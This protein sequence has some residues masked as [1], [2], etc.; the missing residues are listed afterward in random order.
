[1]P[2]NMKAS[3][4]ELESEALTQV[5][6]LGLAHGVCMY[7]AQGQR[8]TPRE[9]TSRRLGVGFV[10][11]LSGHVLAES[12][13]LLSQRSRAKSCGHLEPN[14]QLQPTPKCNAA[15]RGWAVAGA[16]ELRR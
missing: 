13:V 7:A 2:T 4:S 11:M 3:E 6:A 15:T 5:A 12:Q 1:M 10:P 9:W 16:A 14:E 8:H